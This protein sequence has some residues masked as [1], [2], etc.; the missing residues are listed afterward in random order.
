MPFTGSNEHS[1]VAQDNCSIHH[2]NEADAVLQ[3]AGVIIQYLPPYSPDYNPIENTFA[4]VNIIED[5][6]CIFAYWKCDC[7]GLHH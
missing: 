5:F 3:A 6:I 4:K 2:I 7:A 1:V